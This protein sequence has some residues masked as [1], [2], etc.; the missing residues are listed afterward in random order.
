MICIFRF[1]SF[2]GC[3][4]VL[5][6]KNTVFS[7]YFKKIVLA[8]VYLPKVFFMKIDIYINKCIITLVAIFYN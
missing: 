8:A 3:V 2:L 7:H 6:S 1:G 5:A 4:I